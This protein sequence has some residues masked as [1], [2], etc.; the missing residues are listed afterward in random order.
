[1][2]AQNKFKRT[3]FEFDISDHTV[4]RDGNEIEADDV[5]LQAIYLGDEDEI[6]LP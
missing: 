2:G 6:V 3:E 4:D 5:I 1:M